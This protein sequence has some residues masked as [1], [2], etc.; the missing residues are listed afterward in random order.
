MTEPRDGE[1]APAEELRADD[2]VDQTAE[3]V[4]APA[5]DGGVYYQPVVQNGTTVYVIVNP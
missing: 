2:V 3:P 5:A 4:S 1:P